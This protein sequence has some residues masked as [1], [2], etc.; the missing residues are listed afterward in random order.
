MK[1]WQR[2]SL[3]FEIFLTVVA[4]TLLGACGL[5]V[6]EHNAHLQPGSS[7]SEALSF[8]DCFWGAL[9]T[10]TGYGD[11]SPITLGGRLV[12]VVLM[13]SGIGAISVFTAA[14][15]VYFIRSEGLQS[16]ILRRVH[17]HVVICGLGEKGLLL[18]Q[19]FQEQGYFV[20]AVEQDENHPAIRLCREEGMVVLIGDATEP[21]VLRQARVE[22]ARYLL[23]LSDNDSPNAEM[24][25]QARALV[26]A[27]RTTPLVCAAQ[28]VHP[29]LWYLLRQWEIANSGAFRL[30]FFN[31]FDLGARVLLEAHSP[32]SSGT[33]TPHVLI[34]GCGRLGQNVAVYAARRWQEGREQ[35]ANEAR[36]H[37]SLI[38]RDAERIREFLHTR[39]PELPHLC[40]IHTHNMETESA[41]F[42]SAEFLNVPERP[43]VSAIYVCLDDD[44]SA[45]SAALTL[46]HALRRRRVPIVVSMSQNAGLAAL[47]NNTAHYE[48]MIAVG[49]LERVCQPALVLGGTNEILA[50][51][52]HE[53]Y[54]RDQKSQ[55]NTSLAVSWDALPEEIRESNREQ[56][57][58]INERLVSIGCDIMPL[59]DWDAHTFGFSPAEIEQLA[60]LEHARWMQ[61]RQRQGWTHGPR[62]N[63][64]KTNPNLVPW[65]ELPA[66]SQEYNRETARQLPAFL[67]RVG[68]QIYRLDANETALESDRN[69]PSPR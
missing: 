28:I 59:S 27:T 56:A 35:G 58:H 62:D 65:A 47:L 30:Q 34:V 3:L 55:D 7:R 68:L 9:V 51:A 33:A 45:L 10:V 50:R 29:D 15:A 69:F 37:F 39:H 36:L 53:S 25:A 46:N 61:E 18:A 64:R 6:F 11:I 40:E 14:I 60:Q 63:A 20:V 21:K 48:N 16:L 31:S 2:N 19:S 32:E 22:V 44:A 8:T 42:H 43:P 49:L 4:I 17:D 52:I 1:F 41:Q 57:G 38:D 24:A 13:F 5:Y 66:P 12:T 26:P 54:L 67:A 23:C